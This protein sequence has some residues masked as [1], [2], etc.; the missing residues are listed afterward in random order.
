MNTNEALRRQRDAELASLRLDGKRLAVLD[1]EVRELKIENATLARKAN[2]ADHFE[3][4]IESLVSTQKENEKL[5]ETNEVLIANMREWDQVH[6]E[7]AKMQNSVERYQRMHANQEL[8]IVELE[9]RIK[10]YQIETNKQKEELDELRMQRESEERFYAEKIEELTVGHR[11]TPESPTAAVTS[12]T[13]EQELDDDSPVA[14]VQ[15]FEVSR[16]KAENQVLK[17]AASGSV[18]LELEELERARNQL[19][20]NLRKLTEEN[21]ILQEH[22][23]A[24]VHRSDS[25]K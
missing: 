19:D 24:L 2:R 13:L 23:E 5:K 10:I 21:V 15:S 25:E 4:K 1:D 3:K 7:L 9:R 6:A 20:E 18:K 14:P 22:V 16:L 12:K 8:D 11:K 17:N